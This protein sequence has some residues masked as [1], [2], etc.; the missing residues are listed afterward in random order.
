MSRLEPISLG[1]IPELEGVEQM[2]ETVFGFVPNGVRI[3][4]RRPGIVEGFLH[5]RRA[6]FDP[7]TSEVPPELKGLVGH[8]A[9]K[10]AGCRYC[11]AH[12]IY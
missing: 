8:I 10:M 9:S 7:A 6:V 2:Y 3:M 11:Q 1:E 12:A 4:A 5:L